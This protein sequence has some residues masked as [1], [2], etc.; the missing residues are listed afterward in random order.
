MTGVL[1]TW[2]SS[3]IGVFGPGTQAHSVSGRN[4][5]WTPLSSG[6]PLSVTVER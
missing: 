4:T 6:A 2:S 5:P 3:G 1:N